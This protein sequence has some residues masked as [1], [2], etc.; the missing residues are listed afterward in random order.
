VISK[1][2]AGTRGGEAFVINLANGGEVIEFNPESRVAADAQSMAQET[3]QGI[4]D[5]TIKIPLP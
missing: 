3:I 5:G 4:I 1:I 2:K